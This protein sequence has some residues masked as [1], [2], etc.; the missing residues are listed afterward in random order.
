LYLLSPPAKRGRSSGLDTCCWLLLS[1]STLSFSRREVFFF[2]RMVPKNRLGRSLSLT[3][4]SSFTVALRVFVKLP[5][6]RFLGSISLRSWKFFPFPPLPPSSFRMLVPPLGE[7]VI[8][9]PIIY[10]HSQ[11]PLFFAIFANTAGVGDVQCFSVPV[12]LPLC[13]WMRL[14]LEL[15]PKLFLLIDPLELPYASPLFVPEVR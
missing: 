8:H 6:A 7:R 3:S 14:L 2:L 12:L 4:L 1:I 15:F 13:G 9:E 11:P 10:L 5:L